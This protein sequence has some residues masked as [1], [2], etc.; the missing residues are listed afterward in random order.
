MVS[1]MLMVGVLLVQARSR[2]SMPLV[3]PEWL[4]IGRSPTASFCGSSE[5]NSETE[6]NRPMRT[7]GDRIMVG[8]A[9]TGLYNEALPVFQ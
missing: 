5:T 6:R 7:A 9:E 1:R 4:D 8:C 2:G 3:G